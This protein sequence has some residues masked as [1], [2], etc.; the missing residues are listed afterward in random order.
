M[1]VL[2]LLIKREFDLFW[3]NKVL[4]MDFLIM[5]IVLASIVGFVYKKGKVTRQP[6]IVIDK[7]HS[8]SSAQFIDILSDNE[9]VLVKEAAFETADL[10]QLR[11]DKKAVG[12]VVIPYRFEEN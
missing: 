7:D 12:V 11:L 6:I 2:L 10:N 4:V 9:T 8:P 3:K 5:S 1:K